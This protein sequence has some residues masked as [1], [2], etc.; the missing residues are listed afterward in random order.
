M[1]SNL[2]SQ[3]MLVPVIG[4]TAEKGIDRQTQ[5]PWRG[6]IEKIK[7]VVEDREILV[8]RDDIYTVRLDLHPVSRLRDHHGGGALQEF[9]EHAVAAGVEVLDNH[10]SHATIGW[11]ADQKLLKC[12]QP[13]G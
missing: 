12:F 9:R 8:G 13:S 5:A 7:G 3:H 1:T 6:W 4:E 11:D 2:G 10:K